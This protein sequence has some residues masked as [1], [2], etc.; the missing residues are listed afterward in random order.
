MKSAKNIKTLYTLVGSTP[1]TILV[2]LHNSTAI[3]LILEQAIK[4][5]KKTNPTL[6]TMHGMYLN[7]KSI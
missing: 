2:S 1:N 4:N 5:T 3:H 6:C 7:K